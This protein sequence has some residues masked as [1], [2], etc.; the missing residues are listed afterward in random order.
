MSHWTKR[1]IAFL[2]KLNRP[3][4][5]QDYL[6]RVPYRCESILVP[7]IRTLRDHK[8]HCFDG[9]LLAVAALR[10]TNFK[11]VLIDLCAEDDDDHVLCMYRWKRWYGAV[12]KSNFPGL[13]FREPV[14]R[15]VRELVL[16]YVEFYFNLDGKKSLRRYSAPVRL[17]PCSVLD[18]ECDEGTMDEVLLRLERGRHYP[19]LDAKQRTWLRPVD[20]R[21]FKSQMIGVDMKGAYGG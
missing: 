9:A 18:W 13:R 21:L 4:K 3:D 1:E 5:V 15:S 10:R 14:F 19:L 12:A 17:P 2:K 6:D 11:P 8:A 20:K 16:S 7:P